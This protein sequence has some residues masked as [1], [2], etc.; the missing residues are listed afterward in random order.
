V[1]SCLYVGRVRHRRHLPVAHAF[2]LP[3]FML[4]LDLS[5]LD[6]V[7]AGRRL[8]S[9]RRRAFAR[10]D[11]R[12]HLGGGSLPLDEVVRKTVAE[13]GLGWPRGPIRLLTHLRYAGYLFNPVSLYYCFDAADEALVAVVADVHNTPWGERHVY[14]LPAGGEGPGARCQ[15]PKSFHVS[16]FMG[17]DVEYRWRLS[18]PGA[19]LAAHIANHDRADGR[20]IF[21]ASLTLRRREI[22]GRSLARVLARH[23]LMT[24]EVHAAI[25]WQ[26]LRLWWKRVPFHPH[27]R[28]R[29]R[30]ENPA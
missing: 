4:Y 1:Q 13:H 9:T 24:L 21:D 17:M 6:R 15:T 19:R 29:T 8:W 25:Y 14:V 2:A 18:R 10:F 5:E 28:E 30:M 20:R 12:D 11:P 7:F 16:P 27:P 23:P 3:L 26:A 22:G